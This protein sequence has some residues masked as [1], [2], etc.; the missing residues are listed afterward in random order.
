MEQLGAS[1]SI[2][3]ER[4]GLKHEKY[5]FAHLKQYSPDTI[6]YFLYRQHRQLKE[7]GIVVLC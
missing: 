6:F 7:Q 5:I 2:I 4:S 1:I 3:G